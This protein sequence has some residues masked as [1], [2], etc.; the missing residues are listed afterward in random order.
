MTHSISEL[1]TPSRIYLDLIKRKS[2]DVIREL[3][4]SLVMAGEIPNPEPVCG[5]VLDRERLASTAIG[6]GIAIP[7]AF[8]S[9]IEETIIAFGRC[10][11][12]ARFNSVDNLPV[13]LVFLMLGPEA[14]QA[15]HLRLLSKLSRYLHDVNLR[16]DLLTARTPAEVIELMRRKE[17][18][19]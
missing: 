8:S 1:L 4:D 12:G 7:H 16:N 11:R 19:S 6:D 14:T 3:I 15:E 17:G 5:E 18:I 9:S 10:N 13:R 2:A